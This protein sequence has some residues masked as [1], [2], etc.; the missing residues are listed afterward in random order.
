[1]SILLLGRW[2]HGGN[3]VIEESH[4]IEDG[5]QTTIDRHVERQDNSDRMAWACEFLV[6]QHRRA[7]QAAY[8]EYVRDEGARLVDEVEGFEL[9]S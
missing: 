2:D 5:D 9:A 1:M 8:E 6:D 3:L 4:V 7:V